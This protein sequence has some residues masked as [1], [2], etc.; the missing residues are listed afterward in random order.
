MH[1]IIKETGFNT[2][3]HHICTMISSC[4]FRRSFVNCI[5]VPGRLQTNIA[6]HKFRRSFSVNGPLAC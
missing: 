2:V 5:E 4:G 1:G 3:R 6:Q